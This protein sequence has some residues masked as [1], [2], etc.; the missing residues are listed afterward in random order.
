MKIN[1]KIPHKK[2]ETNHGKIGGECTESFVRELLINPG[3]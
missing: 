1:K 2:S 3:H